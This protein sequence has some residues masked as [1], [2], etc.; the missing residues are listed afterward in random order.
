MVM[1]YPNKSP[2]ELISSILN[3]A[4]LPSIYLRLVEIINAPQSSA[5]H[6]ANI[7]S[8]D[9]GLTARLLKIVNSAHFGYQG[10]IETVNRAVTILGTKQL[11]E[12]VL[13]TS[14]VKM[15]KNIPQDLV[16]M[17]SFW[18]H[19]LACG[20]FAKNIAQQKKEPNPERYFTAGLLHDIGRLILF[21]QMPVVAKE[22]MEDA[23]KNSELLYLKERERL[24]FD[25]AILGGLLLD[26]WKLPIQ[27]QEAVR[28]HHAPR[29]AKSF[30]IEA[31]IIHVADILANALQYGTSGERFV[32]PLDQASYDFTKL[33]AKTLPY[34]LDSV[35]SVIDDAVRSVLQ[36]V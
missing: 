17:D 25:H 21:I 12:L 13:A 36:P 18:L 3:I 35:E 8:D 5:D 32:P 15:F 24:G 30:Q 6:F 22:I 31:S 2:R 9:T 16:D 1:E 27:H 4:S 14:V 19:S 7:L 10:R 20:L 26:Q 11:C 29:M 28:Y 33:D 34:L 23:K